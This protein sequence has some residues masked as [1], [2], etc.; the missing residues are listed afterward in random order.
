MSY[1]T[2]E[3]VAEHLNLTVSQVRETRRRNAYPGNLGRQRGRRLLFSPEQVQAGPQ[4][5][6]T[7]NDPMTAILWALSGI[8]T[9][10]RSIHNELRG[11][12]PRFFDAVLAETT[13]EIETEDDDGE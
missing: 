11:Q 5:P 2:I 12:R 13:I 6:E 9:T 8:H 1:W 10:L 7:T 4:E 3:E